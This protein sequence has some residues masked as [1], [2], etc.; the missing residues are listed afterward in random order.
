MSPCHGED[1]QFKSDRGR[2]FFT[3]KRASVAQLV[4]QRTE[5]P[6]VDSSILSWGTIVFHAVVVEWQTR[7]LE[8]VVERTLVRVQVPPTAPKYKDLQFAVGPFY[9]DF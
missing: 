4:E 5:N 1:R 3:K 8:G 2:H 9:Y 7:H 6:C